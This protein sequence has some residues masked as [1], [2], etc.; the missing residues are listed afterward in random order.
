MNSTGSSL[1]R[2]DCDTE[3]DHQ[4]SIRPISPVH[5]SRLSRRQFARRTAGAM[6]GV[7][8]AALLAACGT[9]GEKAGVATVPGTFGGKMT[10]ALVG[11]EQQHPPR[12]LEG[13]KTKHPKLEIETFAGAWNPTLEKV[14][15]MVAAGTPPD[16]WYGENG[17]ATGWGPRNWIRDLAPY[18]K[19]DLKE[20]EYFP[21]AMPKDPTNH[22]WAVAGDLQVVA[23]FYNTNAFA[24][25]GL[26]PPTPNWKLSDLTDA[27]RRLT[28]PGKKQFGFFS[29][30]NYITSSWYL[31][32]KLFGTGVLDNTLTKSQFNQPKVL[33]AF[34]SLLSFADRGMAP[35]FNDQGKYPFALAQNAEGRSAMQLHIY[36]R[37]GDASMKD[38][39]FDVELVPS[40]PGGRWTTVISNAWVIGKQ[41]TQPDAA[42]D[43][44]KWHSQTEQQIV[45]ASSGTG[46]PMNK[47]AAEEVV[48]R[49]PAPPKNRR[50]FLK[51]LDFAGTLGENAVWQEWRT[52]AQRELLKAFNGSEPLSNVLQETHR[53][54]QLELDTF[55]KK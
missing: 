49:A 15:E 23:L 42:W 39:P 36:A 47:K 4:L 21:V 45:R 27:A 30:P 16:V 13:F 31:F 10:I 18:V 50:A 22:V 5:A 28:D 38:F 43:W 8:L 24:E 32:P 12:I 51:G 54:V 11:G 6:A 2:S 14:A 29:Q 19:R 1:V 26:A 3:H 25:V 44:I 7:P 37:L 20:S 9:A 52:V 55:Y 35:P 53:L 41:S 17:R 40:G 46:L 34:Q 48:D 33:E